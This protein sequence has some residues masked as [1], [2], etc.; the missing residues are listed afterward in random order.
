[1]GQPRILIVDDF[2][3]NVFLLE[4][5]LLTLGMVTEK[6]QNGEEAVRAVA[7]KDYSMVFMD[8]EMPIMNGFEATEEIRANLPHPKNIT[9]IVA[10]SAHA[11]DF[12][13]EKVSESGLSDYISK[14]Y[15]LSKIQRVL[16]KYGISQSF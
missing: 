16:T 1:M 6:A 7:Q 5:M 9:P 14:P 3:D 15:T 2:P 4:E 12:F 8:I 11:S 10:I 13:E